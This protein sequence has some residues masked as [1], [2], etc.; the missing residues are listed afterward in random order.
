MGE[1]ARALVLE[2]Y[3]W[4]TIAKRLEQIYARVTGLEAG[5]ARAA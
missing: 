2:H 5:T 4:P 1:A 3:S